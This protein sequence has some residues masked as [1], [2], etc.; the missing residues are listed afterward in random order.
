MHLKANIHKAQSRSYV[1]N[2][3]D[4][5]LQIKSGDQISIV[6]RT[7][8]NIS[9]YSTWTI[10]RLRCT[11]EAFKNNGEKVIY[12][13]RNALC[14]QWKKFSIL[15]LL[16]KWLDESEVNRTILSLLLGSNTTGHYQCCAQA[17]PLTLCIDT[18]SNRDLVLRLLLAMFQRL[19]GESTWRDQW[20]LHAD[21]AGQPQMAFR[22]P[23]Q[24]DPPW[25][26]GTS[27]R[28]AL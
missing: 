23:K 11:P 18:S 19:R 2:V 4:F 6:L 12:K 24:L 16:L 27:R 9:I 28:G 10:D 1:H 5:T 15:T 3:V 17:L 8:N 14:Y 7:W 13:C 25:W 22:W 26:R 20:R 21:G